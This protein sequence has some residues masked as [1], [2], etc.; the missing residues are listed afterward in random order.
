MFFPNYSPFSQVLSLLFQA[1]FKI[2]TMG[3]IESC[4]QEKNFGNIIKDIKDNNNNKQLFI[5]F[6]KI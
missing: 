5:L 4:L 1:F 2:D 3:L 6:V